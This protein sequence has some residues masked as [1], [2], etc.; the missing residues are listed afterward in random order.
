MRA[1]ARFT[2]QS[3]RF[4]PGS[5]RCLRDV[6]RLIDQL[7]ATVMRHALGE[8][9]GSLELCDLIHSACR[10]ALVVTLINIPGGDFR[11]VVALEWLRST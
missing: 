10:S 1:N 9:V 4:S 5:L 7:Q 2:P 11:A 3:F 8:F 6:R